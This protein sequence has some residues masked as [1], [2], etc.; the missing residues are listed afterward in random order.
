ML[1]ILMYHRVGKGKHSNCLETLKAHLQFLKK[2]YPTVLPG[3]QLSK[4]TLNV[5][6]SFDDAL[7]DFYAYTY[8]LLCKYQIRAL[9]AVPVKYI[10][11]KSHLPLEKRLAIPYYDCMKEKIY[12]EKA[13]FCTWEEIQEM[14]SSGFVE[15]ASH[16]Y[17]HVPIIDDIPNL[18]QEVLQSKEIL[19]SHIPQ[20]ISTF[21]YPFGKIGQKTH[22]F[23][24][25]HYTYSMR[26]GNALNWDWKSPTSILYRINADN[27][28]D[29][30]KLF[31][32]KSY[33]KSYCKL[34]SNNLFKRC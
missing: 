14:A 18:S 11:E 12:K 22:E 23:V 24:Q 10:L 4:E 33:L 32:W 25:N 19:Q 9:L 1:Q 13:P 30:S 2:H 6:L 21:I 16:S 17:S 15:M 26:I 27:L 28:K 34:L 8:P 5:C 7:C 3:D 29:L 20:K 31:T